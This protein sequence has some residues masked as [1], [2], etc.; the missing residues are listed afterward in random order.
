VCSLGELFISQNQLTEARELYI[1]HLLSLSSEREMTEV[2][3]AAAWLE[4][5]YFHD[6]T[7]AEELIELALIQSPSSSRAHVALARLEG[8]LNRQRSQSGKDATRKRLADTCINIDNNEMPKP[9]DGRL[10]NAWAAIEVKS[11]RFDLAR[12]I[13]S[14]GRERFPNDK[15][16]SC[17]I[18]VICNEAL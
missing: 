12:K 10:F 14:K 2:Y 16:V 5:K 7:R 17:I 11:R 4:E 9:T 8:R 18:L 3:L 6:M 1:R 13:L 15:D